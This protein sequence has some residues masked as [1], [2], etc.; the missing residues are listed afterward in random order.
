MHPDYRPGWFYL[1]ENDDL[2]YHCWK[3]RRTGVLEN[4]TLIFPQDAQFVPV[5][6]CPTKRVYALKFARGDKQLFFWM[7]EKNQNKDE[8]LC[9]KVNEI[10]R[11]K[12]G[13]R[14]R[15]QLKEL[16][17]NGKIALGQKNSSTQEKGSRIK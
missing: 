6:K 15:D 5:P 13:V 8:R 12:H 11:Y 3:D 1:V 9:K 4:E 7:Q 16:V 14:K 2:V 17:C 10:L